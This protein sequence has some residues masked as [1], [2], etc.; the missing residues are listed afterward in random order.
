ML[1]DELVMPDEPIT[2]FVTRYSGITREK[3]RGCTTR[4]PDIHGRLQR[5]MGADTILVG[6]SLECDLRALRL[7][8]RNCVDTAVLYP[9]ADS[10]SRKSP[11][12]VLAHNLL[13]RTIQDGS[14]G[15]DPA[16]DARAALDL[17]L[18]KFRRGAVVPLP[19]PHTHA[20]TYT[21]V[22][23]H[24]YIHTHTRTHIPTHTQARAQFYMHTY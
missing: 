19:T 4:I 21:Y 15:H 16:E 13:R 7:V 5:L 23:V 2:D 11:L 24:A 20:H 3:L 12:R 8:H 14:D 1:L 10:S 18:L 17:A 22:H 9:P 6:H